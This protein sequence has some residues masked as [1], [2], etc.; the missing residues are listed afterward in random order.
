MFCSGCKQ[1]IK[2]KDK[3]FL[4]CI[5]CEGHYHCECLNI[6]PQ[7]FSVLTEDYISSW[8]CPSCNNVTRRT[9][10]NVNTP[11]RD[12][13]IPACDVSMDIS[14]NTKDSPVQQQCINNSKS[15]GEI[16]FGTFTQALYGKL[17]E[18]RNETNNDIMSI[19]D[20]IK[21][22]LS[23]IKDEIKSLKTEHITLKSNVAVLTQDVSSL[24][25][26]VQYCNSEHEDL[27]KRVEDVANRQVDTSP[28]LTSLEAKIDSLEQQARQC[29]LELCNI[30]EKRNEHL[31]GI[32]NSLGLA[33]KV[34]IKPQDIISVHRVPQAQHNSSRP[35][36]I[37]VK[38]TTRIQR[39]NVLGAYRRIK[40]LKTDQLDI[41]GT[42]CRI[43]LNEHLTLKNK[44][45][46]RKCREVAKENNFKYV[47]VRN[48]A[49]LVRER[50]DTAAFVIRSES[51]LDKI[52]PSISSTR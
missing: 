52:K 9:R 41:P 27:K 21:C 50:D 5:N 33:L 15:L 22:T 24:K 16:D 4:N 51:D 26:S 42:Q 31:P 11:V 10:S 39:D 43:Y 13:Q 6:K 40:T 2:T 48:S 29:N 30:P 18:W 3:N 44:H 7:Q 35:K 37:I 32:V 45:L 46:F 25:T 28:A 8:M 38:F 17:Q 36:N 34:P 47:W 14:F 20:D 12:N 49:V 19:R 23:E 1:K